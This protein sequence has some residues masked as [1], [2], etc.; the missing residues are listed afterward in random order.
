MI[1]ASNFYVQVTTDRPQETHMW[2]HFAELVYKIKAGGQ[3]DYSWL[4]QSTLCNKLCVAVDESAHSGGAQID[5][6]GWL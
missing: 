4:E 6:R 3:A 2:E 1:E 5:L